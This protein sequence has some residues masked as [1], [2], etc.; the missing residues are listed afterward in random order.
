MLKD[1]LKYISHGKTIFPVKNQGKKPLTMHGHKDASLEGDQIEEW[2]TTWVDANIGLVCSRANNLCVLD[3]DPRNG[4]DKSL[5]RMVEKYGQLPSTVEVNTGGGGKHY[6][7][8]YDD[9]FGIERS[10]A[11]GID[12]KK[13]GYVVAPPSVHPSGGR[14]S[15]VTGKSIDDISIAKAPGWLLKGQ[16][17]GATE[18]ITQLYKDIPEGGRNNALARIV[19]AQ[20]NQGLNPSECFQLALAVNQGYNPPLD[21]EEVRSVV[22]SIWQTHNSGIRLGVNNSLEAP[23]SLVC[24]LKRDIP[25]VEYFIKDVLKK[26]GRTMISAPTNT[27][28]SIAAQQIALSVS[29]AFEDEDL[30]AQFEVEMGK[31]LYLDW[32]MGDSV[33]KERFSKMLDDKSAVD[34]LFLKSMLGINIGDEKVKDELE[35]WIKDLEIDLLVLDPI[36]SAWQGDENSKEEVNKLTSFLDSL[37][38]KY[39]VSILLVHHWRKATKDI[40]KG[41]E[42]AAGSYK[43]SAWL[44]HHITLN[45]QSSSVKLTCEKSRTGVRFEPIVVG[46]NPDSLLFEFVGDCKSK[47]S[48]EDVI[49]LI[50]DMCKEK[51][52]DRVSIPDLI[53][54][55]KKK[56]GPGRCKI[57]EITKDCEKIEL[58]TKEKTH[59]VRL[60]EEPMLLS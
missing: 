41:G 11:K 9:D 23:E 40:S 37:I 7:F 15:F 2:W 59:Y 33:L 17:R 48:E 10:F 36:G 19:G 39:G 27:G 52:E 38:D 21:E 55:S 13:N 1:A 49:I 20:I 30:F 58:L 24:F 53:R 18:T 50:E 12:C 54:Y 43:W 8:L 51:N 6:Y 44:D 60:V 28:K 45:G 47:Y 56:G 35:C 14:Y 5:I 57:R 29:G 42:M 16:E 26:E 46:L 25:P 3:I 31:V 32:E 22:M 4:G 34:S